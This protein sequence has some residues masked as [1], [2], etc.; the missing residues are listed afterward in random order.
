M[1]KKLIVIGDP[2]FKTTNL[3]EVD[4]FVEKI[5]ELANQ[6]WP[7]MII[8][9][10]DLLHEHERLH[11]TP[12]NKAYD[13]IRKMSEIAPTVVLVGN[14]DLINNRQFL[15]ENHW[16]NAMKEWDHVTIID[17]V[18]K[19]GDFVFCPYVPPGEFEA[20][21]QTNPEVDYK[22]DDG[23]IFCHQE[24]FG[25]KMGAIDSI[26][27]DKWPKG[28]TPVI[29]GHI[30]SRQMLENVYYPGAA[31]QHAFGESEKNII[32]IIEYTSPASSYKLEEIDL[33][34]PRKKIVYMEVDNVDKFEPKPQ[35]EGISDQVK[36]TLSGNYEEFKA[37]RKSSKYKDLTKK[38]VKIVFKQKRVKDSKENEELDDVDE[39]DFNKILLDLIHQV[40]NSELKGHL[41]GD[42][43]YVILDKEKDSEILVI[44]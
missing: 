34:L 24:F 18:E 22:S 31:M 21:L 11:T 43:N 16:M 20:A 15:T 3:P 13:F 28:Y 40:K 9:L 36:L 12:L 29:S 1:V 30:H 10:G 6:I 8:V 7:D 32:A 19:I 35:K 27:G 25:C 14:H 44:D 37:F 4:L 41:L 39:K 33:K 17:K 5:E 42:Y 38:G 26:E 2:H 23:I